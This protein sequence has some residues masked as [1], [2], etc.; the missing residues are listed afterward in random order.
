MHNAVM[1]TEDAPFIDA[2]A[3]DAAALAASYMGPIQL[4]AIQTMCSVWPAGTL[5]DD[6]REPLTTAKPVLLLS[7][8]ADPITPPEYAEMAAVNLSYAWH[9]T[10]KDQGHGLAAVGC[11]PRVINEFIKVRKLEK[12]SANC[13]DD[14]FSMPFFLD[15]S[16]PAP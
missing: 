3:I 12:D 1:C 6:L 15:F 4:E 7:G 5:D 8:E 14:A 13:L 11:M 9:L 10:G 2:A 16:G